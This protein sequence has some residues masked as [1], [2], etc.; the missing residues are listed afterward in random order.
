MEYLVIEFPD[1]ETLPTS[2]LELIE[3]VDKI[4]NFMVSHEIYSIYFTN[5]YEANMLNPE[6][7]HKLKTIKELFK[8]KNIMMSCHLDLEIYMDQIYD[9]SVDD[10]ENIVPASDKIETCPIENYINQKP[11]FLKMTELEISNLATIFVRANDHENFG[12]IVSMERTA[13]RLDQND[14]EISKMI[15]E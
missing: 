15:G 10:N 4:A 7:R 3:F 14:V 11:H 13:K 2:N 12:K 1:Q 5:N 6:D 8:S 9:F